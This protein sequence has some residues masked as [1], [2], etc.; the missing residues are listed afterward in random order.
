MKH[1]KKGS[2]QPGDEFIAFRLIR[3]GLSALF[4]GLIRVYQYVISPVIPASCRFFP[5]CS[6]YGIQ[7]IRKHGPFR[8]GWLT[9]K[10]IAKCH[11]WGPHGNDPVP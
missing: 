11:P 1:H 4:T 3:I 6:A 8:G 9:L 10:R 5:T 7:A 2:A